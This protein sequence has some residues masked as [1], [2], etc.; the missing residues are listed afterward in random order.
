MDMSSIKKYFFFQNYKNYLFE[1]IEK[2]II[3]RDFVLTQ[4]QFFIIGLPRS[5]TTLIYQYI[6]HRLH[7]AYFTNKVGKYSFAPC[8]ISLLSKLFNRQYFSDFESSFGKIKGNMAPREAG[9][10]WLRFFDIDL[11]QGEHLLTEE[12]IKKIVNTVFCIQNIF[13]DSP[14]INK[15]VKHMLRIK[16]LSELFPDSYFI[17]VKRDHIDVALSILSARKKNL[18][19][20]HDWWS[21][22]PTSYEEI[23]KKHYLEQIALQ[24]FDLNK[25]IDEDLMEIP[26]D[27]I[28]YLN[29]EN[30]CLKP[31][32]IIDLIKIRSKG[33]KYKNDQIKN[34]KNRK[35]KN[36]SEEEIILGEKIKKLFK[37]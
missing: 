30:F 31:D 2:I 4:P 33:V 9:S 34:F 20:I 28:I 8:T 26:K 17:I 12:N 27:R 24:V 1:S 36:L 6:V 11:Y 10:F 15:N 13:S 25:K 21:V 23:K 7:M 37:K 29:Y 16:L 14:F 5:G 3:K 32:G 22:K 19:N 35:K 18:K